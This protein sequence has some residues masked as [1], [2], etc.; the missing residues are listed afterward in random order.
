MT[1]SAALA[2][3]PPAPRSKARALRELLRSPELAFIMEAHSG[4]SAKVVEEAGFA[5]IWASGLSISAA[6][7]VRDNNEASWTQVLEVLEFMADATTIPIMVDGDT[8]YGNFNNVRRLVAKLCQ[9]GVAAVCIED[10]LFPKTNSFIGENQ[11][12]A[13][14]DEF[15]GRIKAGKDSQTD[16]DFSI[17]ARVEALISGWGIDEALKR[18]EAY[19][20]SGAD[21]ILIHSKQSQPDEILEFCRLWGSRAPVVIVPTMYYATPTDVFRRAGVSLA[22]WANHNMRASLGAMR[23]VSRKIK[24]EE[25][26]IGV[27]GTIPS[28]KEVFEITGN[29]ELA[30]AERR[31]LPARQ[32]LR[33]VLLGAS[34]GA[35]LA[36]LTEDRPKCMLDI[37]GEPL[38][39]RLIATLRESGVG[40]I[41]VV[42]GYKKEAISI[43]G[44]VPLD[45]DAYETTGESASL[46]V[47]SA[48]LVGPCLVG[49]ADI[50]FRRYILDHLLETEG[51]I[52]LVV[53]AHGA[54]RHRVRPGDLVKCSRPYT[55]ELLEDEPARV[56]EFLPRVDAGADGEWIGL[57]KLSARGAERVGREIEAMRADATLA[58]ADLPELF[59]RLLVAGERLDVAWI[60][61]HWLD[62]NDAFDLAQARNFL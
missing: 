11:P 61:G 40:D 5:G 58:R 15:C 37:R 34:R 18:A 23:E 14:I 16:A 19:A 62:V 60:N 43:P 1:H 52:V 49:Y 20:R 41:A 9:R 2:A 53:D 32:N 28:V 33:A 57:V 31:Y 54:G 47:A 6:L 29:R 48:R 45:N 17:V 21:A 55:G 25:S 44:I 35:G 8:G 46:A 4:L 12:L 3:R 42:R 36:A 24:A 30:D 56:T 38:L 26:L 7:G 27:E 22:I 39:H 51:D 59:Q 10:K 50:L 13:D